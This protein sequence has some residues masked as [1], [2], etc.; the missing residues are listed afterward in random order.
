M[1][2]LHEQLAILLEFYPKIFFIP[3]DGTTN[4]QYEALLEIDRRLK[5]LDLILKIETEF[6][7]EYFAEMIED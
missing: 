7:Y 2:D 6:S 4:K 5:V 3:K 1:T